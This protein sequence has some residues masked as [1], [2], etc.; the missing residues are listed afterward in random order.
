MKSREP[1]W[2]AKAIAKVA[3]EQFGGLREMFEAHG[4]PE[5]GSQMMPAQQKRV[6]EAYGSV[7][8]FADKFLKGEN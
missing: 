6:K 7:E 5:R 8:A 4:W 3:K 1:G 2:D